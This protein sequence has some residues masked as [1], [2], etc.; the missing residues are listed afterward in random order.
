M[1]GKNCDLSGGIGGDLSLY[2]AAS[3]KLFHPKMKLLDRDY[4]YVFLK[5]PLNNSPDV[6]GSSGL[7]VSYYKFKPII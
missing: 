5:N 7:A 3:L 1:L 2:L 6:F 4:L